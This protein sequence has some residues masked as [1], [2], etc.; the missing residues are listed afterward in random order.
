[1][2]IDNFELGIRSVT[3]TTSPSGEVVEMDPVEWSKNDYFVNLQNTEEDEP[4]E[5]AKAPSM[6]RSRKKPPGVAKAKPKQVGE[7]LLEAA[8]DRDLKKRGLK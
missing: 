1:M 8:Y 2:A 3:H 6:K 7:E 4:Q 5:E